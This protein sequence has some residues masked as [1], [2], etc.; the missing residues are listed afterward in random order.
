METAKDTGC[1]ARWDSKFFEIANAIGKERTKS[2]QFIGTK[3]NGED[4]G[5]GKMILYIHMTTHKR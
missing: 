3:G 1:R 4:N 5:G 2:H